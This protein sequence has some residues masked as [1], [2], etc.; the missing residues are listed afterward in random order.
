MIKTGKNL[1][2]SGRGLI[3]AALVAGVTLSGLGAASAQSDDTSPAVD[4]SDAFN[5]PSS[6]TLLGKED[7]NLRKATAVV[8]GFVITGTDIDQRMALVIDANKGATVSPEE[9]ERLRLQVL[10]NLIDET[11]QIQE[12]KALDIEVTRDEIAQTYERVSTNNFNKPS[13][14]LDAHLKKIGSSPQSLKRQIEGELAWQ[15][16]LSRNVEPF[17]SVSKEEV[18]EILKRLQESKGTEE[19]RIGEIYLTAT[20]ENQQAVF[21]NGKKIMDQLKA[22]GSFVAYARQYSQASSAVVGGDLGWLRLGL[23]PAEL[24]A[25]A[26]QMEPGQLVGPIQVPGGFS[27]LYLID[28]RQVLTADPRDAVLSLKQIS[29]KFP[30]GLP[31]AQAEAKLAE[32][33]AGL[34]QMHGCGDSDPIAAKMGAEVV[35]NDQMSARALPEQLAQNLLKLSLGQYYGPFGSMEEGVRVLMLCGRDDPQ[36]NEGPDFDQVMKQIEDDRVNKR[37]Q[38]YL[39]DLR[40][41]A[42]I[43]YN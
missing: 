3:A 24:G 39:R 14:E 4:T 36:V 30:P 22:G 42:I 21:D 16:I 6:I 35:T 20:P 32:F 23:L 2:N 17:I 27:L 37:A 31:Q 19:Y 13:A 34:A 43:D 29:L 25:A 11:L 9:K 28:K 41:D 1:L 26:K 7:P 38:R 8:N 15:R 18:D 33:N 12:A 5:L 40:R 10:R